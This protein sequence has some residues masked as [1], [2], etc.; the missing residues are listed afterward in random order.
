MTKPFTKN[1]IQTRLL[2]WFGGEYVGEDIYGNRYYQ[3]K[4]L[5]G[6][7]NRPLRRWVLYKNEPEASTIPA[8]WFGWIHFTHEHPLLKREKYNWE[9]P[10][11]ENLT[12]TAHA[13]NPESYVLKPSVAKT[14]PKRYEPWQPKS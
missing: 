11:Q 3:E 10:H 1:S 2:T 8:E 12:G 7:F 13:Y 9:K 6:K 14:L 5:F 4:L